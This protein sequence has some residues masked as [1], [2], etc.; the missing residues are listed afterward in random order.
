MRHGRLRRPLTWIGL[1][2]LV[3][4]L[5]APMA[6]AAAAAAPAGVRTATAAASGTSG[7]S[8]TG[9]DPVDAAGCLLPF[10]SD[11]FTTRDRRTATGLRVDFSAAAMPANA[12]GVRVDPTEWNRNDGFSPGQGLLVHV[13]GI[14]LARSGIAP[15]TDIGRSLAADAPIVLI[16]T[17]TGRRHPYWA[18]LDSRAAGEPDRQLLMIRPARNFDEGTRYVV[19][20]RGLRDATGRLVPADPV[21][22]SLRSWV[23]PRDRTLYRRWVYA[24]RALLSL[25]LAR[26]DL[27]GLHLAWDF[28]VASRRSLTE[29]A[30]HLRDEAFRRLGRGSPAFSVTG[31]TDY[32]PE[33][34]PLIRRQVTGTLTVP[35]YLDRPGGPPGSRLNYGTDGLPEQ[36]PGNTQQAV[37]ICNIPRTASAAHPAR[38]ALYGHGLLGGPGE[39]NSARLKQYM[40]ESTTMMCATP[41]IGM[42]SED[43]I[44]VLG[45]LGD[46]SRFP[47]IPDRLQQSFLNF[48]YLGRAIRTGLAAAP[49]FRDAGGAGLVDARPGRL[50]YLGNSQGGILG[51][52]LTALAQDFTRSALGVPAQ[53]FSVLLNRST[54]FDRF[55]PF[56]EPAYPDKIDQQ[57]LLQLA[58]M[59]WD[60][61]EANGYAAHMTDR[62]LPRTPRHQV[63]LI[64][65]VG[66]HQVAN[67]QTEVEARTIGA[68]LRTPAVAPGRSLDVTP[69]WGIRPLRSS[70]HRPYRGSVLVVVDSGSPL[71]PPAN[72]PPREGADPHGHPH[73][74]PEIRAMVATFLG[75]G[76]FVDTC[77]GAPC[78]APPG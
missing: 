55:L 56:V 4:A 20:L 12:Q 10:P 69:F 21:F 9:C 44:N 53:N 19:A 77:R 31:V 76:V 23:P 8:G 14:D 51:G 70:P 48:L 40:A 15:V 67:V 54:N 57:V 58:Q 26:V 32:T 11:Y 16:N 30:L 66:D 1:A 72:T 37:F 65:A 36:V 74:S 60:R 68:R 64:E 42:A 13:P 33:Q 62:P 49:A 50:V 22:A 71:P 3:S 18:E 52:A 29:R 34:D 47:S 35:S 7:T 75:S 2:G 41:W 46:F 24:Q 39:I 28:T 61:G 38:P 17:R 5:V 43:V 45:V 59:L 73:N 6:P 27:R 25:R 63:I 78:T